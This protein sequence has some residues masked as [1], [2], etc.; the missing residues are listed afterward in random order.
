[1]AAEQF[2]LAGST[3]VRGFTERATATDNGYVANAEVYTPE[4]AKGSSSN[5]GLRFLMFYDFARGTNSGV[6]YGSL[7]PIKVGIGSVGA[8]LRYNVGKNFSLRMDLANVVDA[9]PPNTKEKGDWRGHAN[10]M[11]AF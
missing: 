9:G 5:R 3:A 4:F 10:V 2:G 8:G 1:M 7:T 11:L 6:P